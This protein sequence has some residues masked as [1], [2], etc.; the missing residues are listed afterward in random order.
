MYIVSQDYESVFYVRFPEFK[1]N[2]NLEKL[3]IKPLIC[4]SVNILGMF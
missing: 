2:C 1:L 3:N 4:L